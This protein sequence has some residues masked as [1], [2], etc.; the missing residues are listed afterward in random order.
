MG[1]EKPKENLSSVTRRSFL[2]G[3]GTGAVVTTATSIGIGK[4]REAEGHPLQIE[5]GVPKVAIRL[6]VNGFAYK[7]EVEPR[8]SLADVIRKD[9]GFT[10]TKIGCDRGECGACTI[11]ME[12]LPVYSCTLL[13]FQAQGKMISTIESLSDGGELHP[14][15]QAFIE[16]DAFQCGFCTP[17]MILSVKALLDRNS[18][19]TRED[20]KRAISGNLCRCANYM[21]IIDASMEAAKM[22]TS[23]QRSAVIGPFRA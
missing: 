17:G 10:G 21:H 1:E 9:I 2:K 15:Q 4:P 8:R 13:A 3:L 23:L 18:E 6:N 12:G 11:L 20:V 19:P 14:I 5:E 16:K 7:L 22:M